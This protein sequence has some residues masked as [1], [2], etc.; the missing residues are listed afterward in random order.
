MNW[1][2]YALMAAIFATGYMLFLEWNAFSE[3]KARA[4][5]AEPSVVSSNSAQLPTQAS[6]GG[7]PTQT[8][9]ENPSNG[10]LPSA[11]VVNAAPTTPTS[12]KSA[13]QALIS[14]RTDSVEMLI[15]RFGGDIVQVALTKHRQQLTP[16]SPAFIL[17]Q[18]TH[19]DTYFAQSGLIGP[20]GTDKSSSERPLYNA[21]ADSYVLTDNEDTLSVDLTYVQDDV[22]ITK[23]FTFK[24]DSYL[25]DIDYIVQNNSSETWQ[26]APYGQIRRSDFDVKSDVGIGMQ[27]YLGAAITTN[28]KNYDKV[29][30]D[31][32]EEKPIAV[33]KDGGWVSMVQHY[34]ISAWVPDQEKQ[35]Q[36]NMRK[37][38]SRDLYILEYTGPTTS[39]Q[40][41][42]QAE[43]QSAFYA[44][45]K[46]LKELEKISPYLDLTLDYSWLWFIAKPLFFGLDFIHGFVG[47]WGVA[48]II[49][50]LCIKLL[51]FYPSA[52]GYRSMARMKKMQPIMADLKERYGDDKQKMSG[53]LMKIYKKEKINPLGGCLPILIQMPVFIALYWTLMESVELR[54]APFIFW[55]KDLSVKDPS[56]ILPL[57]MGVTMWIQQKLNPTISADPMQAKIMQYMPIGFTLLFLMFP[58]GLV[59]Y[60]V[61]NNTLSIAQQWII[62]KQIE[63][64]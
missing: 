29:S 5:A 41:G 7:I 40:P 63:K 27:P 28:D 33:T 2:R 26:A 6:E 53:E 24:H 34:F 45:P 58:A 59:L 43:I 64:G 37:L 50:T 54:H 11:P 56:F 21:S 61:V 3:A 17:M 9:S 38:S 23:R 4:E 20:N 22:S 47:N 52:M 57:T 30:F 12:T 48:I 1:L 8:Y 31:D 19:G 13:T 16:D 32:I 60:W 10:E 55:I 14:I 46:H 36:F 35:N 18:R 42:E 15:D 44:G 51:F 39:V 62:N 49:L 25:I